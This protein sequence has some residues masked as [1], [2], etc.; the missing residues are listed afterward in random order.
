[1]VRAARAEPRSGSPG[2][3]CC[4]PLVAAIVDRRLR[5]L[6]ARSLEDLEKQGRG[7]AALAA[8]GGGL[9]AAGLL[10]AVGAIL[11]MLVTERLERLGP[12]PNGRTPPEQL[13]LDDEPP[14]G[15]SARRAGASAGERLPGA[16]TPGSAGSATRAP[17]DLVEGNTIASFERAVEIGV[18]MV[19]FDVLRLRDGAPGAAA[20]A[21]VAAR[22]RPRLARRRDPRRALTL[23]DALDAFTRPPL[24]RV[25][26]DCDLKL[27]GR[28]DELVRAL[29]ERELVDRAMVSTMYVESLAADRRARAARCGSAG[30]IR[31]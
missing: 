23:D 26:I 2:S 29:Q 30:P 13:P 5:E 14:G 10:A 20:G 18:D 12:A 31:W 6:G 15:A 9:T 24:D 1:M 8:L 27:R 25:E 17:R 4:S 19:E 11:R 21:A 16:R 28:E 22:H 3:S 7:V